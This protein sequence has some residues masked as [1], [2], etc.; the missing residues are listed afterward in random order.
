MML[1]IDH[2]LCPKC[3][4]TADSNMLGEGKEF[5][6]RVRVWWPDEFLGERSTVPYPV[7]CLECGELMDVT[8]G[9]EVK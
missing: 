4:F 5:G 8:R 3:G 1:R 9:E 7:R 6:C 2:L